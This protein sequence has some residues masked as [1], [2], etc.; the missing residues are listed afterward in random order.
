MTLVELMVA[1]AIIAIV[2]G[3]GVPSFATWVRNSQIRTATE[4]IKNGLQLAQAEAL[5]RNTSVRFQLTS[6]VDN[7]CAL[8]TTAANWIVN[9][10][11]SASNDPSGS[12]GAAPS[13]TDAPYIVQSRSANEGGGNNVAV[14]ASQSTVVFN[15]LGQAVNLAGGS[16]AIN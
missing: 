13:D 8:S 4:S 16:A 7:T 11:D 5:R 15:G 1:V 9:R 14:A 3:V 2:L 6:S 10:G 12:C